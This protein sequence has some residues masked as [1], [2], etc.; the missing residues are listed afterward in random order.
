MRQARAKSNPEL[1]ASHRYQVRFA[2]GPDEIRAAQKLRYHVFAEEYGAR[3]K[4]SEPGLDVDYYD[5]YCEH[6]IVHD[7][8]R[9]E[10]VGTY[11][12]LT[13]GAAQRVGSYY[14]E[15]EFDLSNLTHIRHGIVEV[16]RSCVAAEHRTGS[17][18]TLLWMKIAEYMVQNDYGYLIGCASIHMQD[19]GHNAANL[20]L[21]LGKENLAP[22]EYRVAPRIKL[23][24]DTLANNQPAEMPPLIRGYLR[25][26]CWVCGEPAWDPD[27]NSAD[28]LLLLPMSKISARYQRH[29]IRS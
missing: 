26:G 29:F 6:L 9:D 5:K 22:P 7:G 21:R 11:R 28:L 13:P 2:S 12:V 16:G 20:Y 24:Y 25:A 3:L 1:P 18:I 4:T 8:H 23:P 14:S 15:S 17:V 10:I 27:F 19:G